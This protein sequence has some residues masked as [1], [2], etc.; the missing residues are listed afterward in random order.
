MVSSYAIDENDGDFPMWTILIDLTWEKNGRIT[1]DPELE[2]DET[3]EGV[4]IR[5]ISTKK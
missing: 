2:S 1:D 3:T 4:K 5:G